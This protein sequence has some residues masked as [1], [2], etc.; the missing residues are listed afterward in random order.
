MNPEKTTITKRR[1]K[2]P[3]AKE[4]HHQSGLIGKYL[5]YRK[6][7]NNQAATMSLI[8]LLLNQNV[9]IENHFVNRGREDTGKSAQKELLLVNLHSVFL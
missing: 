6:K 9:H 8:I 7:Q 1:P 3:Q 2:E 4:T 5:F